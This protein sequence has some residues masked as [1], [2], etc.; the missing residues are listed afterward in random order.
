M[1]AQDGVGDST[2]SFDPPA[3]RNTA[4]SASGCWPPDSV[5]VPFAMQNGTPPTQNQQASADQKVTA[6]K[7]ALSGSCLGS[8]M[9][10]TASASGYDRAESNQNRCSAKA[11]GA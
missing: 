1:P 10:A 8:H 3:W 9:I 5:I 2:Y 11:L 4:R 7:I 6:S